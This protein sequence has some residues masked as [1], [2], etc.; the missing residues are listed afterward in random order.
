MRLSD[1]FAMTVLKR[2]NHVLKVLKLNKDQNEQKLFKG[3]TME[4]TDCDATQS[5]C[6]KGC[7]KK[8]RLHY[9]IILIFVYLVV[10]AFKQG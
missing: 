5:C 3:N 10:N 8:I 1:I 7:C 9:V 4:N 2:N 6:S